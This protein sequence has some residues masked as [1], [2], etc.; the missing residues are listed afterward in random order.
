MSHVVPITL[1]TGCLGAGKTTLLNRLLARDPAVRTAV[2]E[3][4][5]GEIS[6]DDRFLVFANDDLIVS[7]A[8]SDSL[9]L[10]GDIIRSLLALARRPEPV[11]RVMVETAGLA[12]PGALVQ[13]FLVDEEIRRL[14]RLEQVIAVVDAAHPPS[15]AAGSELVRRQAAFADVILLNKSDLTTGA[16]IDAL[17]RDLR[18]VNRLAR[19][20]RCR[21]ADAPPSEFEGASHLSFERALN[22]DPHFLQPDYPFRWAGVYPIDEYGAEL[23]LEDGD[24]R[25]TGVVVIPVRSTHGSTLADA[26]E[27]AALAFSDPE[28]ALVE[29][30]QPLFPGGTL[31][32]LK[33]NGKLV[34][35]P[36]HT[37]GRSLYAVFLKH[38]P[39]QLRTTVRVNGVPLMPRWERTFHPRHQVPEEI[40]SVG[41]RVPGTVD[42]VRV[43]DWLRSLHTDSRQEILRSKGVLH[44]HGTGERMLVNGVHAHVEDYHD[45][46]WKR[47]EEP[48]NVLVFIGRNLD[49]NRL[50]CDFRA[51]LAPNEQLVARSA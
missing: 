47:D 2:I 29:P 40:V 27:A 48:S 11:E 45:F 14:F 50:L 18:R 7:R 25:E 12:D 4:E 42:P 46:A 49:R 9:T 34:R 17:E 21:H 26:K 51:C 6:V 35:H 16:S 38:T 19:V 31:S 37:V 23:W 41:L 5:H 44:L 36:I 20:V 15:D 22:L 32:R 30:G 28:A 10:R 43:R 13:A 24:L 39:Q 1:I 33:S 8:G 3:T